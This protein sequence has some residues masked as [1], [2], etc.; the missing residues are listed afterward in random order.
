[1]KK[2]FKILFLFVIVFTVTFKGFSQTADVAKGCI[3]LKVT[4]S[5]PSSSS[6]YYWN[7]Q[8][9]VTSNIQNPINIFNKSGT[10]NVTFQESINGPVVGTIKIVVFADPIINIQATSGCA[11][12]N[13]QLQNASIIDTA[14]KI[15]NYTWIFD[16]GQSIEGSNA[17]KVS[18]SYGTAG[19]YSVSFNIQTQYPTCNKTV[20]FNDIV[21]VYTPP[22]ASFSTTP[23]NTVTCKDTLNVS[24]KS[25]SSGAQPLSYSWNFG[26]GKTSTSISPP[27]QVYYQGQYNA[28]LNVNYPPNL[29]GCTASYSQGI[30]LGKPVAKI[31]SY[32]DTA[33]AGA[34]SL[35][36]PVFFITNSPGILSWKASDNN[37]GIISPPPFNTTMDTA[38]VYFDTKGFHTITLT[39]TSP[40]G[41][42]SSSTSVQVYADLVTAQITQ[43][44]SYSCLSPEIIQY[45][46]A[47]NQTNVSYLWTFQHIVDDTLFSNSSATTQNITKKIY[48]SSANDYYSVNT[49]ELIL[50]SFWATSNKTGCTGINLSIDT[51]WLPNAQFKT[52]IVQGCGPLTVTFNDT[53]TGNNYPIVK[54]EWIFGDGTT[55]TNTSNA[56]VSHTY[57][58][59]GVYP[60]RLLITT[61]NGCTD[62]SYAINI[63]VGTTITSGLDFTVDKTSICPGQPVQFTPL[64]SA[65]NQKLIDAY[66]YT[67]E[68]NRSFHCSDQSSL[69]WSYNN[70]VGPQ[71]VSLTVEY[72]GC[73]TTVT[74]TGF[75][76]VNGAIA[77]IDYTSLCSDPLQYN[78]DSQSLNATSLTWDFG[79]TQTS[80]DLTVSHVYTSGNYLVKLTALN[81]S[82][83]CA[84]T[85]DTITVHPRKLKAVI[86]LDS[87][88]CSGISNTFDGSLSTDVYNSCG[89]GGYTWDFPNNIFPDSVDRPLNTSNSIAAFLY[90]TSGVHSI[91]L[92]VKDINGCID[93]TV[94][95]FKVFGVRPQISV[96]DSLICVPD[97]LYFMSHITSDTTLVKWVWNFGDN[98]VDSVLN[99][100]HAYLKPPASGSAFN[101]SLT[102]T[103]K[104]GCVGIGNLPVN[105]Y[106]P[107]S[108]IIISDAALCLGQPT[109]ISA[110]DFTSGG[111]HLSYQWNFGNGQKS[112]TQ[113]KTILYTKDTTYTVTLNYQEI[114]TGCKDS[115]SAI[116]SVQT[117][118]KAG[119]MTSVDSLTVLCAPQNIFFQDSSISK[120]S[121]N[122]IWNFGNGQTSN[123]ANFALFYAKGNYTAT[124][125]VQTS[126]GCADSV[127]RKFKVYSPEGI[128]TTSTDSICRSQAITFKILD[129]ADVTSYSWAFGDGVIAEN[130][131]PVTHIYNFHPPSGQTVAKLSIIGAEG[132]QVQLQTPIYIRQVVASFQRAKGGLDTSICFN[133][134]PFPLLNTSYD[135]VGTSNLAN[136]LS[137]LW[138]FGD[139]QTTTQMNPGTHAYTTPGVY[140]VSLFVS[141]PVFGCKDTLIKKAVIYKN[142]VTVATGDTVCQGKP[143]FLHILH[144][145]TLSTFLW[146]PAQYLSSATSTN[147]VATNP[148]TQIYILVETD[149]NNCTTT[150]TVPA[151]IIEPIGL[152]NYDT[153]IVIGDSIHL[154]AYLQPQN[155]YNYIWSPPTALSCIYCLSPWA[156]PLQDTIYNLNVTD[157]RGCFNNNYTYNIIVR[158]QTFVKMPT[159]FTPDGPPSDRILYVRGWGI[160]QLLEFQIYN[161]WGQLLY[162]SANINEGWDGTFNGQLQSSDVYVYKVKALTWKDAE[163]K[164]EGYVNLIR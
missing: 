103:D 157:K 66:H 91:R 32:P 35:G 74:K 38:A 85:T 13:S 155:V 60:A 21:N 115:T 40:D 33:C 89:Y 42:C 29:V 114:S 141:D 145:D 62:T 69:S 84:A 122:Y 53:S 54:W 102:V 18:H 11:P 97:T 98:G 163:I 132:C 48:S 95:T 138:N 159:A 144:P 67:T 55:L 134:G 104:L 77:I 129:T 78:F 151:V 158:P 143:V 139:G 150:V 27:A 81:A 147:P 5:A 30:S 19:K 20:I 121:L 57:T 136:T 140:N 49:K 17:T 86:K 90:K 112:T 93:T 99:P 82:G 26:N 6:T 51:L 137:Y 50:T 113:S 7:F 39:V 31:I 128:F 52:D 149:T 83:G 156:Q 105:S 15:S 28:S 65:A 64:V 154:N 92:I 107:S 76:T 24:F 14:I 16:D 160:K 117:Y 70:V 4:F 80:T 2:S 109:T 61:K 119:M 108:S 68:G 162:S 25:T 161:R 125:T 101:V 135:S 46:G 63:Q 75:V 153:S 131:A 110:T 94:S 34:S 152:S 118:P 127:S 3:P 126:N 58:Q 88:L 79:D 130:T 47:S 142:P 72:N 87:L 59:P 120:Y 22:V 45:K 73:M 56:A 36:L 23:A 111:S 41:S 106:A 133:D 1:M 116:V 71:N 43:T 44:P 96:N 123:Q 9:G 148:H 8:D 100:I 146:S 10:Y 124:H 12:L 164:Q 37:T